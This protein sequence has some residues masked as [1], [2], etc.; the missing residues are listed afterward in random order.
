MYICMCLNVC[1]LVSRL[2]LPLPFPGEFGFVV[3][4]DTNPG[5]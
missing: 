3:A 5:P 4:A 2:L 1:F